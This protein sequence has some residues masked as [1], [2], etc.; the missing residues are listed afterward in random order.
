MIKH[1]LK[2]GLLIDSYT[3]PSWVFDMVD[4]IK[5]SEHS[6]ITLIVLKKETPQPTKNSFLKNLWKKRSVILFEIYNKIDKKIFK[7]SPYAFTPKNLKDNV[8]CSEI[9][10]SPN[11]INHNDCITEADINQ[12]KTYDID[13]FIKLGFNNLVGEI[14][15]SSKFGIWAYHHAD[16]N[17]KRANH[18]SGAWE[19]FE[20][21]DETKAVVLKLSED[22]ENCVKLHE[23]FFS[24]DHVSIKRNMNMLYRNSVSILP[25]KLDELF[26]IGE[27]EFFQKL[28]K[29][30]TEPLFY[31]NRDFKAPTN[32]EFIKVFYI[33][34]EKAI[35]GMISRKFYISQWIILFKLNKT[36]KISKSFYKFKR[37]LPPKDSFWAD[38]FVFEKND[39][40]YIFIE[41][42]V[43]K[44]HKG[45]IS[46]IEMDQN[47]NY[48]QPTVVLEKDY[49]LS[50]PFLIEDGGEL[51]MM[52][53]TEE[54]RTIELYKCVDFPTKWE[55]KKV[56]IND[57]MAVD[58]TI[59]KHNDKFWLF[60][61][62]KEYKGINVINE[63]MLFYT[64]NLLEGNWESHPQN[65]I[66]IDHRH[67]RPAG[68]IF[69]LNDR[70]FRPGQDCSKH[71]GYGM[72]LMEIMTLNENEYEERYIQS[73]YPNWEKDVRSVHT[74]NYSG[75]LTVI[76]AIVKRRR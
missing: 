25:R 36:K 73:I 3:V 49:H 37:I 17:L 59:L 61:N 58:A 54:N 68:N 21:W 57:I 72:Q 38:P 43:N 44:E 32:L 1:K 4:M 12:I 7:P 40:Y 48:G 71:Y 55:L 69:K 75:K 76:D 41:E 74:L 66:A 5:K 10:V 63:L 6:E 65:P 26:Q 34:W 29:Q 15:N 50:Y 22:L 62:V 45:K 16:Y 14:F 2:I 11:V 64:D 23:A 70:I 47:G 18:L 30:K 20:D 31:Y 13:V 46:V 42:F 39:K 27:K 28:K 8:N 24:T 52:P 9:I 51:Y 56:L 33:N 67:S 19:V 60:T 53:E 35:K